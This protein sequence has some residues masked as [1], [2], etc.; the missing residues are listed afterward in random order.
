M[1]YTEGLSKRYRPSTI[2]L[3]SVN[4]ANSILKTE[5]DRIQHFKEKF[6]TTNEET[7]NC[8]REV[9]RILHAPNKYG[10]KAIKKKYA[11]ERFW[12]VSG[13]KLGSQL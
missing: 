10:L 6:K 9:C 12:K 8:F 3:T 4:L 1:S 2:A 11:S 13:V 5:H 7:V